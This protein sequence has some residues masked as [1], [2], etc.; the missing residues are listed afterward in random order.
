MEES[1][2][3][4][5]KASQDFGEMKEMNKEPASADSLSFI[6]PPEAASS[7]PF[8]LNGAVLAYIGDAVY[9]LM[10]RRFVLEHRL[11]GE[12]QHADKLH[13]RTVGLV[14]ARAQS[15]MIRALVPELTDTEVSIFKR[16][17]NASTLSAAKNQSV[18]D[19]R[20]ATGLEALFG[21][22]YLSG[23]TERLKELFAHGLKLLE[24]TEES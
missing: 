17:R 4:D 7:D 5:L 19:Y 22:L 9:E 12:S 15:D 2:K 23:Q 20:R 8:L 21:N 16:G 24:E 10:V 3:N 13:R 1:L 6:L 14:N 18:T 11:S